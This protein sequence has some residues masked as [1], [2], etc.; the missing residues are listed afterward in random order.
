MHYGPRTFFILQAV[1][2]H[3]AIKYYLLPHLY[4]SYSTNYIM[5][6]HP[7]REDCQFFFL[8]CA[9]KSVVVMV[10]CSF[11]AGTQVAAPHSKQWRFKD[12]KSLIKE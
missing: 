7:G 10:T 11:H 3:T 6:F 1:Y 5:Y 12:V 2:L 8:P 4:R 9:C